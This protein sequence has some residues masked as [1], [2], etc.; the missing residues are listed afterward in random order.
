MP[1]NLDEDEEDVK[2]NDDGAKKM[3][4]FESKEKLDKKERPTSGISDNLF[5]DALIASIGNGVKCGCK[6]TVLLVDDNEFNLL[7]LNMMLTTNF[8]LHVKKATNGA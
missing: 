1:I 3:V 4:R 7:P 6:A 5:D 8:N 2:N